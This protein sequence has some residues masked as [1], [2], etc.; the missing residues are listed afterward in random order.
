MYAG[1]EPNMGKTNLSLPC[2]EYLE[3]QD[4]FLGSVPCDS[5]TVNHSRFH[6]IRQCIAHSGRDVGIFGGV[7]FL[8]STVDLY[9]AVL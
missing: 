8:V 5:L 9:F 2:A 4:L 3:R 6:R 1:D 7:V